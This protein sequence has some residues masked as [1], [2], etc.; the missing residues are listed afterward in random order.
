MHLNTGRSFEED[1]VRMIDG[2]THKDFNINIKHTLKEMFG[3]YEE[4]EVFHAGIVPGYQKPDIYIEYKGDRKY[5]SLKTGSAEVIN[6]EDLKKFINYLREWGISKRTIKTFL[7]YHFGDGTLDGS[8]AKRYNWLEYRLKL[9]EDIKLM[10]EELNARKSFVKDFVDRCLF[11][12]PKEGSIPADYIYF[13]TLEY[14]SL[15]SKKQ[16]MRHIENRTWSF[17]DNPHIGPIQ[18]RPHA[19]YIDKEIKNERY[20]WQVMFWWANLQ[21]DLSYIS[22]RYEG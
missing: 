10:N 18:F 3:Y 7:Y 9:S 8:G 2:H 21:R 12:G 22:N 17:M 16:V 13:G 4:D 1:F 11:R 5:I 15:C 20:R 19:R 14:G 6:E